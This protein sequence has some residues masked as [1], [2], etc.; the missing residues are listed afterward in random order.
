[1][2]NE[3][4]DLLVIFYRERLDKLIIKLECYPGKEFCDEYCD[5]RHS[6]FGDSYYQTN[7][8]IGGVEVF[9]RVDFN[10]L[11]KVEKGFFKDKKYI[12]RE[13]TSIMITDMFGVNLILKGTKKDI[14][15]IYSSYM[16]DF[17]KRQNEY[18][19]KNKQI[20]TQK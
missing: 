5:P 7:G 1:M 17:F 13:V 6:R 10:T 20:L 18:A 16:Q 3:K 9:V 8:F 2:T 11:E 4:R 12:K 19:E 14:F 15:E